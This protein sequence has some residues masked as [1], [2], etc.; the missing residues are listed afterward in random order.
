MIG[1]PIP[2]DQPFW[3]LRVRLDGAEYTLHGR[4]NQRA[5]KW[6]LGLSDADGNVLHRGVKVVCHY[7]LFRN[8]VADTAPPG[9]L[10]ALDT[11]SPDPE[12][13]GRDPVLEDFGTRVVLVYVPASEL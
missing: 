10:I 9:N 6:Y 13:E 7:P 4:Y 5:G 8:V 12:T 2:Q 1:I 11:T 3:D